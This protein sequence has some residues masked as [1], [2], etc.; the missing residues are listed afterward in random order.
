MISTKHIRQLLLL[1]GML[2]W[3]TF[4]SAQP[5]EGRFRPYVGAGLNYGSMSVDHHNWGKDYDNL[6]GFLITRSI[7]ENPVLTTFRGGAYYDLN[8][9]FTTR[10]ETGIE[11]K[12]KFIF[13][14]PMYLTAMY[15]WGKQGKKFER[16]WS[17]GLTGGYVYN[18]YLAENFFTWE[19]GVMGKYNQLELRF[20]TVQQVVNTREYVLTNGQTYDVIDMQW[21]KLGLSWSFLDKPQSV[22]AT[23]GE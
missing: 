11:A 21:I 23:A 1:I 13:R 3:A 15:R 9:S 7:N 16:N 8:S 4:T 6:P 19:W 5:N 2:L 18:K 14:T 12:P 10:I 17:V 20:S 22:N